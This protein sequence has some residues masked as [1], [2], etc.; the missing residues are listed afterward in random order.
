MA[1][2]DDV[3]QSMLKTSRKN[4]SGSL[5]KSDF[6]KFYNLAQYQYFNDLKGR[7]QRSMA[8]S[9]GT[10]NDETTSTKLSPFINLNTVV[11]ATN[12]LAIKPSNFV[13]LQAM[14]TT[15][16]KAIQSSSYDR[17]A[18]RIDSAIDPLT[19]DAPCYIQGATV[20]QIYPITVAAV[21]IDYLRLPLKVVW[22]FTYNAQGRQVFDLQNSSNP[23]WLDDD[24]QEIAVRALKLFGT[25]I[26]D[27]ELISLGEQTNIKGE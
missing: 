9:G 5:T 21:N 7:F 12:G 14:R 25:S 23:E 26:K 6:E 3:Y 27:G 17:L 10:F 11:G 22:G 18:S 20:W 24:A 8:A 16:G 2:A 15:G 4:Q 13:R 19:N 1:T